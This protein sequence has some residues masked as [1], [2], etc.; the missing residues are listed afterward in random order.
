MNRVPVL[1]QL[2]ISTEKEEY[3]IISRIS[4]CGATK[5]RLKD[6]AG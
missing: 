4:T 2:I 1:M 6:F 5:E 3:Y